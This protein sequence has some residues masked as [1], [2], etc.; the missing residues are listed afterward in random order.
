MTP[1]EAIRD[2]AG[3]VQRVATRTAGRDAAEDICQAVFL[4][5][6]RKGQVIIDRPNLGGWL[7][8]TTVFVA[9]NHRKKESRRTGKLEEAAA[10]AEKRRREEQPDAEALAHLDQALAGL[11]ASYREPLDNG[12]I[13]LKLRGL[14]L[15]F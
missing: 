12:D 5:L 4:L 1:E 9:L 7:Y 6:L 11:P 3:F 13:R 10:M 14:V 8:R 15:A 2:Y